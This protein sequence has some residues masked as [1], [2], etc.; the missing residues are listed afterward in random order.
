MDGRMDGCRIYCARRCCRGAQLRFGANDNRSEKKSEM[1]LGPKRFTFLG[2]SRL[3]P[4]TLGSTDTHMRFAAT[5]LP[6]AQSRAAGNPSTPS[7]FYYLHLFVYLPFHRVS[8]FS[9][10]LVFGRSAFFLRL[11]H[12]FS[13]ILLSIFAV[14]TGAEGRRRRGGER[15]TGKAVYSCQT[16][17]V[18]QLLSGPCDAGDAAEGLW[19]P[20]KSAIFRPYLAR[21]RTPVVIR[22]CVS[23]KRLSEGKK[24]DRG[25]GVR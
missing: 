20:A 23:Q 7:L 14:R 12:V 21:V 25:R 24:R 3:P 11:C 5:L 18:L 17:L 8:W 13:V 2:C 15:E 9:A 1:K 4:S 19:Y 16:E 10:S 6:H 22:L